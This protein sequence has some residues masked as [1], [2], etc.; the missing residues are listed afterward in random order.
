MGTWRTALLMALAMGVLG[1]ARAYPTLTGPTGLIALPGGEVS[2]SGLLF[3]ADALDQPAGRALP[4]RAQFVFAPGFEFGALYNP[5]NDDAAPD[6]AVGAN[7]KL[8]IG[9]PDGP[10][11]GFGAQFLRLRY[12]AGDERDYWQ[13]YVAWT[14][15]FNPELYDAS[16]LSLTVGA[17][18]TQAKEA[19]ARME[20]LRGFIGARVRMTERIVLVAEYQ[21]KDADLGDAEALSSLGVRLALGDAF[22]VQ[23]GVTNAHGLLAGDVHHFFLGASMLLTNSDDRDYPDISRW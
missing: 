23:A 11:V 7:A 3:A 2:E 22:A 15:D 19:D 13:G 9:L 18:W 8:V 6:Y 1:A 12:P 14:T 4:L 20:A 5:F 16:N 21:T 17:T 10:R